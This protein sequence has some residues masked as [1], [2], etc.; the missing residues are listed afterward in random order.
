MQL[1]EIRIQGVL[2]VNCLVPFCTS[3]M[4]KTPDKILIKLLC[5]INDIF[6]SWQRFE[7]S[8]FLGMR[9]IELSVSA[10]Q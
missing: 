5:L 8:N 10:F 9:D 1:R 4:L 7:F 2:L 3:A 6:K